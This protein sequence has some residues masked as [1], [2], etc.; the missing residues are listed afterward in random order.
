MN[1][2]L[3]GNSDTDPSQDFVG[4][5]DGKSLIVKT[6]GQERAQVTAEGSVGIGLTGPCTSLHV[7]G[8]V[9]TGWDFESAGALTFFPPDGY[10]STATVDVV[11]P[12]CTPLDTL[13]RSVELPQPELGDL[14]GVFQSGAYGLTASPVNFLSHPSP[15]EVLISQ[16][17]AQLIRARG[18]YSDLS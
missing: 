14:I 8:R 9:A 4:T 2:L 10:A 18:A 15:A 7:K 12:L 11:G 1:W 16:G 6:G 17:A 5:T 13:G 3:M